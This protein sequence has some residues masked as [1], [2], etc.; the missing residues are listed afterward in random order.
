MHTFWNDYSK[1]IAQAMASVDQTVLHEF[2]QALGYQTY[3][4]AKIF[5]AGNGG[6]AAVAE[7]ASCDF[8]K[9]VGVD[10]HLRPFFMCL[11]SNASVLTAIGNDFS[12]ED[13]FA[14]QVEWH[15]DTKSA[16]LVISASGN[17]KNVIKA[18]EV[19]KQKSM[20][21][22]ALLGFDGGEIKKRNLAQTI[23]HVQS[24]NYGIVE[25]VHMII[26]HAVTQYLRLRNKLDG[27]NPKL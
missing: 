5:V 9:G 18:L 12:Y 2:Q 25:D 27:V 4:G 24:N 21:T 10:T 6:S 15:G 19:A 14:K 26:I 17:S 16:L 20:R 22:F 13:I 3:M 1:E 11:S 23:L 8:N 7:H